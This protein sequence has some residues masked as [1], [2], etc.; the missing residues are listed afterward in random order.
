MIRL[1]RRTRS[2]LAIAGAAVLLGLG[3]TA[4]WE[5]ARAQS[6][7]H[8]PEMDKT[9]W[10]VRLAP[11]KRTAAIERQ[12]RGF[13]TTMAEVAYRYTEMYW[14]GVDGNWGYAD[15]MAHELDNAIT[16]GLE[17]RPQYRKNAEAL[18]LKG[19]LP[20][21]KEAIKAKDAALFKERIETLRAACTSCHAAEAHPFI[22]IGV[23]T[24]RRNPVV[25]D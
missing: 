22:K 23:P 20:Q 11:A 1:D 17:R 8:M 6:H 24:V 7:V 3:A 19:P 14:G 25:N 15:H 16:L 9:G 21:V 13:E 2:V 18:L 12:L 10:L 5:A 4:G